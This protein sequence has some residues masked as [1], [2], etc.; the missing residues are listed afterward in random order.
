M[1]G[2]EIINMPHNL[3]NAAQ[4]SAVTRDWLDD[5]SGS[6]YGRLWSFNSTRCAPFTSTDTV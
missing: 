3:P 2:F 5:G 1:D 6:D 4:S